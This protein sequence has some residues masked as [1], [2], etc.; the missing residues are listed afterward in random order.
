MYRRI[1]L[2]L[3]VASIILSSTLAHAQSADPRRDA[4]EYAQRCFAVATVVKDDAS[5]RI[6]FDAAM[7][8]GH[9]LNLSNR[10]LNDDFA[11]WSSSEIVKTARN[12]AYK[13]QLLGECRKLG[14]AS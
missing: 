4:Y 12:P 1:G 14:M 11:T 2:A 8:L 3:G 10:Q 7:K 9:L 5:A 13:E 6:A